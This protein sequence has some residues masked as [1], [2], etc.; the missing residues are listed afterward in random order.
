M[1]KTRA[2]MAILLLA[3]G[4]TWALAADDVPDLKGQWEIESEAVR[5]R[6]GEEAP[7]TA[8]LKAL[9]VIDWQEGRRFSG[10]EA[11][12]AGDGAIKPV[13]DAEQFGGVVSFGEMVAIVDENGFRDCRIVSVDRMDCVYR[14]VESDHAV[15][16]WNVWRRRSQ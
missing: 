12:Q 4:G 6:P 14:H 15:V 10:R 2:G 16:A 11:E 5:I 13:A 9:F 7:V 3:G 1:L 8:G